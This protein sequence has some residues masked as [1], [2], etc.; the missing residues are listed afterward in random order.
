[1]A[2]LDEHTRSG[3]WFAVS[4]Q[5]FPKDSL[6]LGWAHANRATGDPGQHNTDGGLNS[7]NAANMYT[8]AW[9]HA[10]DQ[11]LSTYVNFAMTVDHSSAH[12]DQG[13]GGLGVTTNCHDAANP[14]SSGFDP[15]GGAA[16]LLRRRQTAGHFGLHQV[17]FL[18]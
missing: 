10:T 1:M 5:L 6:P 13:A 14:D 15:N 18:A 2:F 16:S 11:N 17:H 7:D 9:K 12:Y 3:Y 8:M 4:Q